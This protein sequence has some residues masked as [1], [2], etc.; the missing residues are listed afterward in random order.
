MHWSKLENKQSGIR[1]VSPEQR[2]TGEDHAI[3]AARNT[4]YTEA[5][6]RNA[7]RWAW[8]TLGWSPMGSAPSTP[9]VT[10]L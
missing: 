8:H 4:F 2:H 1:Y 3:L 10:P 5:K 9:N 7:A 6:E